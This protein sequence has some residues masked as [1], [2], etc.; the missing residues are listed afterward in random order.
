MKLLVGGEWVLEL[1]PKGNRIGL[2]IA[3]ATKQGLSEH[4][5]SDL[6]MLL[7]SGVSTMSAQKLPSA[8]S[9]NVSHKAYANSMHILHFLI[10]NGNFLS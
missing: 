9:C 10:N 7:K 3:S 5:H 8:I 2:N 6:M 4:I 1:P